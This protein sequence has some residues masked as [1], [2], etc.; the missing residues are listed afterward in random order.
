MPAVLDILEPTD[1]VVYGVALDVCD[2]HAVE[3]FLRIGAYKVYLVEDAAKAIYV[4][5]GR[6]LIEDWS[7]KGVTMIHTADVEADALLRKMGT[8]V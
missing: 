6:E 5:K 7:R 2:A 1:I 4:D 3:G 8:A